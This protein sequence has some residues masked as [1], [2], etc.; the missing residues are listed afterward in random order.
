MTARG[1]NRHI[2]RLTERIACAAATHVLCVSSSMR[3]ALIDEQLCRPDKLRVL[4]AGSSNGVDAD[5]RFNPGRFPAVERQRLREQLRIPADALVIGFVGRIVRDKGM[6]EL[7]DAWQ[8]IRRDHSKA[9]LLVV[10]PLEQ[11]DAIPEGLTRQLRSDP[12]VRLVG[13][14]ADMP[15]L[16]ASMDI[17]CLPSYREGFPNVALEAAAMELPVVGTTIPGTVDAI[18]HSVTGLLVKPSDSVA[19]EHALR[20]YLDEPMTRHDHGTAG[21]R[22]AATLFRQDRV[23]EALY[24]YYVVAHRNAPPR[25]QRR[26]G[27]QSHVPAESE[28]SH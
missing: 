4:L 20:R 22:R 19:L 1:I 27:F 3:T 13:L 10:G 25:R 21:R 16:Y 24:E 26:R 23:W 12:H 6:V 8:R 7:W 9:Y 11:S 5:V 28:A 17:L 18:E 15:P 14:Q 2:L